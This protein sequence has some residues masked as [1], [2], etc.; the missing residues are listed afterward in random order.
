M[1]RIRFVM[2]TLLLLLVF[3]S[4]ADDTEKN[5]IVILRKNQ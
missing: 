4:C 3:T 2:G 5:V 1:K